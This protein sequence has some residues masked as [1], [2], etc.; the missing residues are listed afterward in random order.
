MLT[1]TPKIVIPDN[2]MTWFDGCN[3][4][5]VIN[6]RIRTCT[7]MMCLTTEPSKC[8]LFNNFGG[9]ENTVNP[10]KIVNPKYVDCRANGG[11]DP[12]DPCRQTCK[13]GQ[14]TTSMGGTSSWI[15]ID[16]NTSTDLLFRFKTY[17]NE[18]LIKLQTTLKD[19]KFTKFEAYEY[20]S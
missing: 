11:Y 9:T 13:N 5:M 1:E 4:C 2:C 17:E 6:G 10:C 7:E 3:R 14:P 18:T 8:V 19:A 16:S 15:K 20:T 12:I